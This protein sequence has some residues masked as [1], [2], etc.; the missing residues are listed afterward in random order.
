MYCSVI[1][2]LAPIVEECSFDLG[3]CGWTNIGDKDQWKLSSSETFVK[4][5]GKLNKYGY[6]P[7][8]RGQDG[9]ILV[10]FLF[11]VFVDRDGVQIHELSKME[12]GQYPAILTEQVW[13]IKDLLYG[14]RPNFSCGI[15]RVVPSGQD[16]A[17]PL[18]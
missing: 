9:W 18:V 5:P 15:R 17:I 11:C 14:F 1:S 13:S 2:I 6:R 4:Y 8:V 7:S 12:R 10:K 3:H 16:G